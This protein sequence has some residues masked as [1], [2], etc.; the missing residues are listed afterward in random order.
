MNATLPID[1]RPATRPSCAFASWPR[2]PACQH[3]PMPHR[4][5]AAV[6]VRARPPRPSPEVVQLQSKAQA[7]EQQIIGAADAGR[8]AR[9]ADRAGWAAAAAAQTQLDTE[10][11]DLAAANSQLAKTTGLTQAAQATLQS[12]RSR[13]P[14]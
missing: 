3:G 5:P 11:V 1:S 9:G 2:Y 8:A 7:L 12:D 10:Q 6:R 4:L 13:W 14:R